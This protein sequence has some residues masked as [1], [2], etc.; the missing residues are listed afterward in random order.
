MED[1]L[2]CKDLY[3]P[4]E[5]NSAKPEDKTD[6]EWK[7]MNRKM[8]GMVKQWLDDSVFHHVANETSAHDL[9]STSEKPHRISVS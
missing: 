7:R 4:I 1:I 2:Y 6:K 3:D 5:G 8:I 9:F